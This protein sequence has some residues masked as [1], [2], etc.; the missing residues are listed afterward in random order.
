MTGPEADIDP[1]DSL[2]WDPIAVEQAAK[3]KEHTRETIKGFFPRF[4]TVTR[5]YADHFEL[6][7]PPPL[8]PLATPTLRAEI[9]GG[10]HFLSL[11]GHGAAAG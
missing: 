8:V 6:T 1:P 4:S 9:D 7:S 3:E 11:T 2:F 10:W 5:H